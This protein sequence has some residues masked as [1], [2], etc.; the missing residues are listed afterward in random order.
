[1]VEQRIIKSGMTRVDTTLVRSLVNNELFERGMT[2]QLQQQSIIGIPKFDLD[3]IIRTPN[4]ENS[5]ILANSPEAV[6]QTVNEII[7]KQYSL[8]CVFPRH[9]AD[10][11]LDGRIYLH[12]LGYPLRVYCSGHSLAYLALYGLRLDNLA[13]ASAPAK[14]ARVLT[15]HLNTFLASMQAYYAGALGIAYINLFY[16]P[17][18]VG[19]SDEEMKQEAQYLIYS[20]SQN[21]FSRGGQTLFLDFNIHFG[22]PDYLKDVEA[23]LPGGKKDG[24]TFGDFEPEA[25]RFAKALLD[26]YREGDAD[27]NLFPFPKCDCHIDKGTYA[28]PRQ[29]ELLEYACLVASENGSPYLVFDRDAMTVAACC[30]LRTKFDV[31][32][33]KHP[34]R[35]R[36]CGFQNVTINLPQAA[37]RAN[38]DVDELYRQIDEALELAFEAHGVKREFVQGLMEEG[39]PLWQIGRPSEDG[40]SYV[41]L[42][43]STYIVGLLGLTECVQCCTGEELHDSDDALMLGLDIVAYM[44]A[45]CD[46]RAKETGY[47]FSLE[48]SPAES[49]TRR[50]AK[51]DVENWPQAKDYVQGSIEDDN[52][53]Y[54]NSIHVRADAD[55]DLVRRIKLQAKFHSMIHSG[56]II[57]AFVGE[58]RPSP[59]SIYRLVELTFHETG[60]AQLT[61]SPEFT[62]CR[63]CH[64]KSRG[65]HERCPLCG[66]L[67]V[68]GMSRIVGYFSRFSMWNPSKI[69]ER[70]ARRRGDYG[71]GTTA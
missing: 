35:M 34:E 15:G 57:H 9:I 17:Y 38:G 8:D 22:V 59:E 58:E 27:G 2:A 50:M 41:D 64:K 14:H 66:S 21:A 51:L 60:A 63:E 26:V 65:L 11:H 32:M 7:F 6:A 37:Y 18:L 54:T 36:F 1:V 42:K 5:N 16:A 47:T 43:K 20:C 13:T 19:F 10:A 40:F 67:E 52:Y 39:L 61:I 55:L 33:V 29:C 46:Q 49:A 45:W 30:R 4:K 24:R 71:I 31:E 3:N 44:E 12:D 25:Q 56:A 28:D 68:D 70:D 69:G 23:I 48:E 53:Y 62:I